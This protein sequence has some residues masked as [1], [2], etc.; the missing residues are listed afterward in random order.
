MKMPPITCLAYALLC[1]TIGQASAVPLT[2]DEFDELVVGGSQAY[3]PPLKSTPQPQS[4]PPSDA[5]AQ[6]QIM[7]DRRG[8][9]PGV[10]DGRESARLRLAL[11]T[12]NQARP[13]D[14][15]M[16]GLIRASTTDFFIDYEITA[17]DVRGPFTPIIPEL[18][19]DQAEL[20][21]IG[22]R[23]VPEMLAERFH[24]DEDYLK[25]LNPE[26]DFETAGTTI[27]V[28][29]VGRDL[30]IRVA[31]IEADKARLQVRAFAEDGSLIAAYPASIGSQNTPSPSG[32]HTVR[33][34]AQNPQYTYDPNGSAQPGLSKGLVR[35]PAGA[36]SPVGNAW[37]GLSKRTYG[38]HGTPEPSQIGITASVGCVR[39]TNWDALEL[40]RLVRRGVEVT[41]IE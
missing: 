22:F 34:K 19:V 24:M 16:V 33:N 10:I 7:L 1:L 30:Q 17:D 28:A 8:F 39:L 9:S 13:D 23:H 38:I 32:T 36:N 40:A 18:Y 5:I 41:F 35:L 25:A 20:S 3:Q 12:H 11:Q 31:R 21:H 6:I 2:S 37:I 15:L 29:N 27:R 4:A 26:A 14:R